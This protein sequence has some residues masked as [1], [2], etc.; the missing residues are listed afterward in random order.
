MRCGGL[1]D[2]APASS[3]CARSYRT[4]VSVVFFLILVVTMLVCT[5]LEHFIPA[6]SQ[7]GA[8]IIIMPLVMMYGAVALPHWG[9]L[10]LAF[11]AGCIVDLQHVQLIDGVPEIAF[12]WSIILYTVIGVIMSGFRPLYQRGRWELHCLLCGLCTAVIPLTEYLMISIRRQPT[13]FDFTPD[14]WWRIGGAGLSAMFLAPFFFFG[15][16]YIAFLVG[17]DPNPEEE[18]EH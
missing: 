6:M 3:F 2:A 13:H 9:M 11:I 10:A 18:P 15:F 12:G 5:V 8:R 14:I 17:Y 16:N 7:I 4:T 1:P